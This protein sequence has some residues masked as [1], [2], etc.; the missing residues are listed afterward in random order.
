LDGINVEKK[1]GSTEDIKL[2]RR[3]VLDNKVVCGGIS[4]R[5]EKAKITLIICA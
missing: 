5:V 1:S 2:I 3:I 4:K